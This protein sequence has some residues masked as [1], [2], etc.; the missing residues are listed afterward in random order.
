MSSVPK[1]LA[2]SRSKC[3]KFV[4]SL[5]HEKEAAYLPQVIEKVKGHPDYR[6]LPTA[7]TKKLA[8]KLS[9]IELM[10]EYFREYLQEDTPQVT[11]SPG[12]GGTNGGLQGTA[13]AVEGGGGAASI[14]SDITESSDATRS[15]TFSCVQRIAAVIPDRTAP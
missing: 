4:S 1:S 8:K 6:S 13:S 2:A 15:I 9:D 11:S 14:N 10:K 7:E 5:R 3:T 12:Q